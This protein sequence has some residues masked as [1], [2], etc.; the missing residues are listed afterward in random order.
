[1][2]H[3]NNVHCSTLELAS[4]SFATTSYHVLHTQFLVYGL[5]M[6]LLRIWDYK[7]SQVIGQLF[8]EDTTQF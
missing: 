7:N 6:E 3:G 8:C 2:K 1:M 4:V 5:Q